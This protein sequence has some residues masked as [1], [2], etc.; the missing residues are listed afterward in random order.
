MKRVFGFFRAIKP[1]IL[2]PAVCLVFDA[3]SQTPSRKEEAPASPTYVRT[4]KWSHDGH[5]FNTRLTFDLADYQF[6]KNLPKKNAGSAYAGEHAEHPYLVELAKQLDKDAQELGYKDNEL[7]DYLVAFVQEAIPYTRDPYNNGYDYPRFPI[8]TITEQGGD[9]EDKS[10]LLV[11]L[12]NTFGFD[13]VMVALPTHMAAAVACDDRGSYYSYN[14]KKYSFIETTVGG[15][16]IGSVPPECAKVTAKIIEGLAVKT[17]DRDS[18]KTEAASSTVASAETQKS[19]AKAPAKTTTAS[20][21]APAKTSTGAAKTA[22]TVT[23]NGVTH[24][25]KEVHTI[26]VNGTVYK[27]VKY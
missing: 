17:Y 15:W 22:G 18:Q 23:V 27:I 12:L 20:A 1:L 16:E 3:R 25:V 2:V 19:V 24:A 6:Y 21:S 5:E 4:L 11:A 13:A 14:G 7:A 8:E 10:A 9:C 26:V